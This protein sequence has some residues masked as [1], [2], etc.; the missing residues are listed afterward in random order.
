MRHRYGIE[1]DDPLTWDRHPPTGLKSAKKSRAFDTVV[2]PVTAEALDDLFGAEAWVKAK[3]NGNVLVTMPD[4]S[5]WRVPHRIWHSDFEATY[6]PDDLFAVKVWALL[7][8]LVPGGGGTPQLAGSHRL[9]AAIRPGRR[10]PYVQARQARLPQVPPVAEGAL[11]R[12]RRCRSDR[13]ERFMGADA[14]IDGLPARVVE[15]TGDA[16]DVFLTHAWVFHTIAVNA[17]DRP[18]LMRQPRRLPTW[19][20]RRRGLSCVPGPVGRLEVVSPP[21]GRRG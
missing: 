2:G 11:H 19:R 17:T 16:G 9:F 15:L 5:Q 4:A 14:G 20:R 10:G 18:R 12:R 21:G 3:S 7:D 8:D 6:P 1:R 13:T